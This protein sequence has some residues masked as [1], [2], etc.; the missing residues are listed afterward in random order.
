MQFVE[1]ENR[2]GV[3][4]S[5]NVLPS[6]RLD[7]VRMSVPVGCLYSPLK[8]INGLGIVPYKPIFCN[9]QT[10][11]AILNPYCKVDFMSK[12][13]VCP[14]CLGRNHF[15]HHYAE[16]SADN[17]PAEIIPQYTTIEY[18]LDSQ[19][20]KSPVFVFVIDTCLIDE[21]MQA[22]K[23]SILQ[24]L[25]L[26]PENS[27]VGL[28]TYGK[29]VHVHELSFDECFKSYVYRGNKEIVASNLASMLGIR[30]FG[31]QAEQ[32]QQGVGAMNAGG[33]SVGQPENS[34]RFLMPVSECEIQLTSILEDLSK[35]PWP[36]KNTERPERCTGVALQ[37]AVG[38][39]D[40]TVKGCSGRVM[41]FV[42]GATTLGPGMVVSTDL[43]ESMRSHTDIQKGDAQHFKAAIKFY[44]TLG[45]QAAA[46]GHVV[47]VFACSLDQVG[48]AEMRGCV[49]RTGGL[50][51]LD[52]SFTHGVFQG[53][54][55]RLFFR[56]VA[57][58]NDLVMAFS[59]EMQ[60]LTSR[61]FKVCGAIGP[62]VSLDRKSSCIAES[63]IGV[64]NTC[65]WK[66]GGMDHNT[67]V[68]LYFEMANQQQPQQQQQENRQAYL[69]VATKYKHSSGSTHLRVSTISKTLAD[70]K[71][72]Q[73]FT[74]IKAGFDQEC[75]AVLMTRWAVHKTQTEY[76]FD[77]LRWLDR[78]LIKLVSRF[79]TYQKDD[80]TGKSFKLG[81]EFHF[82]PQFMFHLRR[83]Q[84]LQVFNSSPDESAFYRMVC[85]RENCTNCLVMIQ[86]TLTAYSLNGPAAPVTLDV[87]SCAP[88]RI[89]V[90]DTFFH[91]VLWY[92]DTIAKWK[93][94]NIHQKPEY[95]FF[96]QLLKAPVNDIK[97][98]IEK[99]FPTPRFI[100]CVQGH[101]QSR[102][103]MAKLNPSVTQ[104]NVG[105]MG[106]EPPVF[107]EDVSLK[108]FLQ[109]LRRLAVQEQN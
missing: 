6:T 25:M 55:K 36:V 32:K 70:V 89:L 21:E 84:F 19:T 52:D 76:T 31:G 26:L 3:R 42:G 29:N 17:R 5:W 40:A 47:D 22:L 34:Q 33:A 99:R 28:I 101:S 43:K 82:Y 68:A 65:A 105:E 59:G 92:G 11:G 85:L 106:A 53:S 61:E 8:P 93:A 80:T 30:G 95:E 44:D 72:A 97:V 88:D 51:V 60:V 67:T 109:H 73:G 102:F 16:I 2:D 74:Y 56:D 20:K 50:I 63:E 7:A 48:V 107:T 78:Q 15:P 96:G 81:Q 66:I 98:L 38:L 41:L 54:F 64:G 104:S 108:V 58:N 18:K 87:T 49:D 100:E 71:N 1:F 83:S 12:I 62:V 10:C 35:D 94:D 37:V 14:F 9:A 23:T 91:V 79:A 77:I 39:L 13:W 69:Q 57:D 90:L 103:I 46:N 27:L 45:D 4:F 24:S 75:A 86:P